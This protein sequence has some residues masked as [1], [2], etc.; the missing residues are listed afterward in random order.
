M[1][2]DSLN[3]FENLAQYRV[4]KDAP[5]EELN[6]LRIFAGS[7]WLGGVDELGQL[8]VAAQTYRQTG[9]DFWPGSFG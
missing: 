2:P 1:T 8:K 4:P 3:T 9:A 5:D 6:K 7:I